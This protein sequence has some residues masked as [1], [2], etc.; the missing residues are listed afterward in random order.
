MHHNISILHESFTW[1]CH[2]EHI[3]AKAS[4]SLY[5]LKVLKRAG[6]PNDSLKHFY[7]AAIRPI[8]EY[9]SVVW[10]HNLSKK[11]SSQL[12]SIQKRAIRIIYRASARN[13]PIKTHQSV[14]D[15]IWA[16]KTTNRPSVRDAT[17]T[18][19]KNSITMLMFG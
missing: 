18:S 5:F 11:Q 15:L 2:I 10:G 3:T 19:E 1:S 9:C 12:E 8:L 4:K 14:R 13:V 6:L 17:V 16:M 7:I